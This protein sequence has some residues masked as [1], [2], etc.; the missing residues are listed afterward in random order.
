MQAGQSGRGSIMRRHGLMRREE[1]EVFTAGKQRKVLYFFCILLTVLYFVS[2]VPVLGL[3]FYDFPAADD[4]SFSWRGYRAFLSGGAAAAE[5]FSAVPRLYMTWQGNFSGVFFMSLSPMIFGTEYY[6]LT[7]FILIGTLTF[8]VYYFSHALFVRFLG[9]DKTLAAGISSVVLLIL[10]HCMPQEARNEAFYWYN[11][12]IYYVFLHSLGLVFL[13]VLLHLVTDR[14]TGWRIYHFILSLLLALILGGAAYQTSLTYLLAGACGYILFLLYYFRK[15]PY[16]GKELTYV[17]KRGGLLI[18]IPVLVLAAGFAVSAIA[19][20]NSVR[21]ENFSGMGALKSIAVAYL[22]VF[23]YPLGEWLSFIEVCL[24]LILAILLNEAAKKAAWRF[25]FPFLA[26][27]A[28][29]SFAAVPAVPSLYAQGDIAAG[30]IRAVFF[31]VTIFCLALLIFYLSGWAIRTARKNESE[32]ESS[33]QEGAGMAAANRLLAG[34]LLFFVVSLSL[35]IASEPDCVTGSSA[36]AEILDGSAQ[37]YAE[38]QQ[39]RTALLNDGKE[40]DVSLPKLTVSPYLLFHSDITQDPEDWTN[41]AFSQ[42]Y[43]KESVR[44]EE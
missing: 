23:D 2:I 9:T 33:R 36:A 19:P 18:G 21:A 24:L 12:G 28:A 37:R 40:V 43:G 16:G 30:R 7:P 26:A 25:R 39:E 41:K 35:R 31:I 4:Y 15:I 32:E 34:I 17:Q 38:E 5:A 8:A 6:Y 13:G 11:G 42:Y 22:Y 10:V 27:V 29:L 3:S 1:K 14:K 20:G 44:V